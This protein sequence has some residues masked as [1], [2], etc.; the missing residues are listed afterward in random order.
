MRPPGASEHGYDIPA[1]KLQA[2]HD[3][4]LVVYI[5]LGMEPQVERYLTSNPSPSRREVRFTRLIGHDPMPR[6]E[7]GELIEQPSPPPAKPSDPSAAADPHIWLDPLRAAQQVETIRDG[8]VAADPGCAETYRRNAAQ[9]V[10]TAR[11]AARGLR[12][13]D[14][15]ATPEVLDLVAA[16]D[17]LWYAPTE[18]DRLV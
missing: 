16:Y 15:L 6:N 13:A 14:A 12:L 11:T 1:A 10:A 4:D 7:R 9:A 3:A 17:L 5:G 18:L 8:L 2:L